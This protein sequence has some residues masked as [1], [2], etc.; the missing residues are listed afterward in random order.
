MS[1]AM[2]LGRDEAMAIC[3]RALAASRADETEVN[4]LAAAEGLTRFADNHIHQNVAETNYHVI[5]R[6]A[7]ENQVGIATTNDISSDGVE[8]A[9]R[10]A[11]VLAEVASPD[12]R[13]PGLPA[14]GEQPTPLNGFTATAEFDAARRAQ[15]ARICIKVAKERGQSA[16]GA[17]STGVSAH[18]VANSLGVLA[19]QESTRA[20]L[21]MVFSGDDSSGYAAKY[22]EDASEIQ[23]RALAETAAGKCKRS[24]N[25]KPFD[26]GRCDVVLEPAAV[27]DMI[28][29]LGISA[30][31]GLAYH[32]GRSAISGRLGEQVCGDNIALIDDPLDP[33]GL[34]RA[35]DFEGVP[36]SRVE[37]IADGVTGAVVHDSRTA[38]LEDARSTGHAL[39]PSSSHGPVPMNLFL[40]PGGAAM[41]EMVG[42]TDRG[43]LVTR[44]HYTNLVD[45]SAAVL[46]G[47]TRD[48]IFLIENGEVA[49]GVRNLRFTEAILEALSRVEMIGREGR[50]ASYAWAPPLLI[51]DFHFSGTTEF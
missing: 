46:T 32:E 15:A 22:A 51:R 21:R 7:F 24:A 47:M 6:A 40:R 2:L 25:P 9:L 17:C 35:F 39:P 34:R 43:L 38:K 20:N 13:Y 49:G 48:G 4:L 36:C 3:E 28:W 41:D 18:A 31:G 27:A 29:F 33:R 16:A 5:I 23:P 19:W 10:R 8:D 11:T 12:E 37:L 26:P 44:F 42:A 14:P 45:P 1:E 50:L 30:F